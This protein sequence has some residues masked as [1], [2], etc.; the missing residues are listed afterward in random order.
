MIRK[1]GYTTFKVFE[2]D[3]LPKLRDQ[4]L[5]TCRE[6]PEFSDAKNNQYVLGG[7]GALGNPSSFHNYFI[8]YV[9]Y[10]VYLK[11]KNLL[12]DEF[13][14]KN[15]QTLFDRMLLRIKGQSPIKESW[16]RDVTPGLNETD[17][18]LG[19]W[20]NFDD[21]SNYFSCVPGTHEKSKT[22]GFVIIKDQKFNGTKIEV[23]PGY[24]ILFHQNI[25]H[26]VLPVKLNYD[27]LRIFHGFRITSDFDPIFDYSKTIEDQGVPPLPSGQTPPMY[28]K[29]HWVNHIQKVEN[30]SNTLKPE[31]TEIKLRES[32]KTKHKI[33]HRFMK[34][35]K[36]Y[37]FPLYDQY[38]KKERDIFTPHAL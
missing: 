1:E 7:F 26:E 17:V 9:R 29:M 36:E 24:G 34:S 37:S 12:K 2:E 21:K 19:G 32:T 20:T 4:F 35:L 23:K 30:F 5:Q 25:I 13:E 28:A 8:R 16:H 33:V 31:C 15:I 38:D 14:H 10:K 6:F 22:S 27:T 3:E 11:V 18:V